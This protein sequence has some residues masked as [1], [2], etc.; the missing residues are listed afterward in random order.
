MLHICIKYAKYEVH[1]SFCGKTDICVS[2][3]IRNFNL[4]IKNSVKMNFTSLEKRTSEH[5]STSESQRKFFHFSKCVGR[6]GIC[7]HT[8]A[9]PTYSRALWVP[10]CYCRCPGGPG[11]GF[12]RSCCL[13]PTHDVL[14]FVLILKQ[15]CRQDLIMY[16]L[17]DGGESGRM[18]LEFR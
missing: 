4:N 9:H 12:H 11:Q 2:H 17:F 14:K 5:I 10:Q 18:S 13:I 8:P 6:T 7:T 16:R 15:Q 1:K 3:L